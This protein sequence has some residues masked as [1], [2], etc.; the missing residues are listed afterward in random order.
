[1]TIQ[2]HIRTTVFSINKD[3]TFRELSEEAQQDFGWT[4][5]DNFATELCRF[6]FQAI[7]NEVEY[8]TQSL[9]PW[10]GVLIFNERF[11]GVAV[12]AMARP[13]V[14]NDKLMGLQWLISEID[15]QTA[16]RA[17]NYYR[18][19]N[20]PHFRRFLLKL[21]SKKLKHFDDAYRKSP[22]INLIGCQSSYRS[23]YAIYMYRLKDAAV[24][25]LTN[26]LANGTKDITEAVKLSSR[27]ADDTV[28]KTQSVE[29]NL[30]SFAAAMEEMTSTV[31]DIANNANQAS[32]FT[33]EVQ[34]SM[35]SVSVQ[36]KENQEDAARLNRLARAVSSKNHDVV[37]SS[38]TVEQVIR[39]INDIAEQTNLLALNAAIE[40]AR[41]GENGRGFSVVADEVR[42]LS[43]RTQTSVSEVESTLAAMVKHIHACS[44]LIEQ[45]KQ[46]AQDCEENCAQSAAL[47]TTATDQ[48]QQ[49]NDGMTQIAVAAEEHTAAVTEM[50][51]SIQSISSAVSETRDKAAGTRQ[52]LKDISLNAR[53]FR[54]L[55]AAFEEE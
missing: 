33:S 53:E 29:N 12:E 2:K 25:F 1:M 15:E 41:A 14:R 16:S 38:K 27:N 13:I 11:G 54:S 32:S 46:L 26:R 17:K 8:F 23:N 50:N 51:Q 21:S 47:I 40:A 52:E 30:H 3:W 18:T 28:E 6:C 7:R 45:Q 24:E 9:E 37:E 34:N 35:A 49:V 19:K 42:Q 20:L 10:L 5:D 39:Q 55:V 48:I 4:Q 22:Q 31:A 36:V 44:E 43:T